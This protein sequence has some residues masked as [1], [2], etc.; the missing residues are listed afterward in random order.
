MKNTPIDAADRVLISSNVFTG[1]EAQARPAFVAIRKD[2][3]VAVGAP[4]EAASWIGPDTEVHDLKDAF[5][6]PGVHDNHVF[7]TGYMS[8]HRG[9]DLS[10]T[11]SVEEGLQ[12]LL[13]ESKKLPP[14]QNVYAFG[15][16]REVWGQAPEQKLLDEHFP[17]LAVVAINDSKSYCWMNRAAEERYRFTPDQCSAEARALLLEE[18]MKDKEMLK[19]EF[20][21][22]CTMLAGRGVTSIKDIGFDRYEGLLPVL[23][24]L[25]AAGEL[26]I[27]VHFA[28]EPVLHPFDMDAGVDYK[29]R[30]N[31]DK[32][33]FQGYKLMLDGVVA[34]H[35]GD[36]LE[37]Y[38]DL[39]GVTNLRPVD[40][41]PI[42]EAVLL[43]D[44]HGIKCCLTAEGDAAIRRAVDM[45]EQCRRRTG[46]T[47]RHSISDLEYPHP[48][49]LVRMGKLGIFA[50]VYAQILLLNPSHDAAYMAEVAGEANEYR[51]YNYD[52]MLKAGVPVTIGTDLPLFMTSVPDS[53]Y[54][55]S[56]R[57][58]PDGSPAEGWYPEFGMPPHEVLKAWTINGAEHCYMAESTGS[59][60]P[61]KYAD[62]AVFD[63]DLLKAGAAEIRDAQVILTLAAGKVTHNH[64][65]IMRGSYGNS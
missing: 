4:D 13:D 57:R 54:A 61:G 31:S 5:V 35:T 38:A 44:S 12:R 28:L 55:A 46:Q 15:W 56:H 34:D 24:E 6:M 3:I 64:T 40:Y 50:E 43:A 14:E 53:L 11:R 36:M 52:S 18:M 21:D 7:F 65:G 26:P 48:D 39:P 62:I 22:F 41:A 2:R 37:P 25:E 20:L 29:Q 42:E 59:L 19:Q 51:F 60:E 58:F 9:I 8:M 33:R 63:R 27:R 1:T 23:N 17:G 10:S 32:L 49:D 47:V 45:L 16:N 30:Y